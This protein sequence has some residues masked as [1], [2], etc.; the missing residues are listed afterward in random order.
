MAEISD[1]DITW[2]INKACQKPKVYGY[3][4]ELWY[5]VSFTCFFFLS[6][7]G[8]SRAVYQDGR[9]LVKDRGAG[10]AVRV[11]TSRQPLKRGVS[12]D[13]DGAHSGNHRRVF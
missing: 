7:C 3:S 6:L 10:A 13:G 1:A 4:A 12:G 9:F 5:P 8:A 11:R 2:V